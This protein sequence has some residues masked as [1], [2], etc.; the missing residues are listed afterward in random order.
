VVTVAKQYTSLKIPLKM[1][2]GTLES[3]GPCAM[4]I[5]QEPPLM[6]GDYTDP[7]VPSD[8]TDSNSQGEVKKITWVEEGS[9]GLPLAAPSSSIRG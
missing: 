9:I 2:E 5:E 6:D 8:T 1:E 7:D 3:R 4:A